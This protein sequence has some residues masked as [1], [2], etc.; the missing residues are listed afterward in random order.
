MP[1]QQKTADPIPVAQTAE[2][3]GDST[4][5]ESTPELPC[6]SW[7]SLLCSDDGRRQSRR[8]CFVSREKRASVGSGMGGVGAGRGSF[9]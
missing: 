4:S 8:H 5:K 7:Q 3:G 1:G 9:A 2:V 6:A